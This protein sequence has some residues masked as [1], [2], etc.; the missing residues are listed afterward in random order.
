MPAGVESLPWRGPGPGRPDLALPPDRMHR[1]RYGTWLKRWR[2]IGVFADEMLACSARVEVGVLGQTF[3]VVWDRAGKRFWE[4][5]KLRLPGARGEVWT[6]G[7]DRP[8]S[9]DVAPLEGSTTR[10]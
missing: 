2:Y 1:R 10:V 4:Q 6:E 3:W 8:G 5:T 7:P 9:R